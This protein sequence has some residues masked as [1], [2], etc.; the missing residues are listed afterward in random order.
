VVNTRRAS[1]RDAV[2]KTNDT[3][4]E[5]MQG[6]LQVW[7][8]NSKRIKDILGKVSEAQ[9]P[10][11]THQEYQGLKLEYQNILANAYKEIDAIESYLNQIEGDRARLLSSDLT[12]TATQLKKLNFQKHSVINQSIKV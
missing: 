8:E 7:N 9:L 11:L 1:L 12:E 2:R 5:K 4:T 6:F 3:M 10:L